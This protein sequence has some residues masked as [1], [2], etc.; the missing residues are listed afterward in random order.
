MPATVTFACAAMLVSYLPYSAA[1][2]VL[3]TLAH[4]TGAT[5]DELQW[6]SDAFAVAVAATVLSAGV[7]GDVFGRRRLALVGLALTALG[8]AVGLG[9]GWLPGTDAVHGLWVA[10][11]IA[12][13]GAGTVM[14]S[15]LGSLAAA[16]S[17]SSGRNRLVSLW[18][19]AIV[20]GLGT[21]PFLAAPIVAHGSWQW[22][23]AP[24]LVLALTVAGFGAAR[25]QESSAPVGRRLDVGGQFTGALAVLALTFGVIHGGGRGFAST[26]AVCA[27]ALAALLFVAFAQV[28]RRSRSPLLGPEL[29]RSGG[30]TAAGLAA[31]A[32]MFA[33]SGGLFVL[34]LFFAHQRVSEIGIALRLGCLFLGNALATQ[35]ASPLQ[36]RS[37]PWTVLLAGLALLTLGTL[38]LLTISD[39]TSLAEFGWRLVLVGAGGGLVLATASAVAVQAVPALLVGMAGAANNAMRQLGSALGPAVL[40]AVLTARLR[41]GDTYARAVHLCAGVIVAVFALAAISAGLLLAQRHHRTEP[42]E[43]RR[44]E[45]P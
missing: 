4:V 27:L 33:I 28:E 29:F 10:Q 18:V 24:I 35:A 16:A 14:S 12:G 3:G 43:T 7:L 31:F 1:N 5:T 30:F 23:Y 26:L 22:L 34:S 21:G 32:V 38:T 11:A 25:S 42:F 2:A 13:A 6:V 20:A 15:T 40:G 39:A 9:A 36:A 44:D 41:A 17:D 37:G 45:T 8:A 19:A